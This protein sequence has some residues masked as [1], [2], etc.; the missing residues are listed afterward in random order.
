MCVRWPF[1]CEI[2]PSNFFWVSRACE[3]TFLQIFSTP[4]VRW[5]FCKFFLHPVWDDLFCKFFLHLVW[6]D[7][8]ANFPYTPYEMTFLQIF[9][10]PR[11][12]WPFCVQFFVWDPRSK[13][14]DRHYI[15]IIIIVRFYMWVVPRPNLRN[16]HYTLC[17]FCTC[18]ISIL[19]ISSFTV[20]TQW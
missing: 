3:M 15:P 2:Y 19:R 6:D 1:V 5:P 17:K 11:V 18:E 9:P 12:R 16:R 10:T 8:F 7:L 13:F 14:N 20:E 4:R